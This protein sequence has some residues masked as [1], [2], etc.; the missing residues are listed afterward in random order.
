MHGSPALIWIQNNEVFGF[1]GGTDLEHNENYILS[2]Q[3]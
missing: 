1:G 3:L 2:G